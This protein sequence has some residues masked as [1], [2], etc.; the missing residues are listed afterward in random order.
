MIFVKGEDTH[1]QVESTTPVVIQSTAIA[2]P[3]IN[4]AA[5]I[6]STARVETE[7]KELPKASGNIT[8]PSHKEG[9]HA[10]YSFVCL[11]I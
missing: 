4:Q 2:T 3:E 9:N 1:E 5:E 11:L 10:S 6:T 7:A 8:A